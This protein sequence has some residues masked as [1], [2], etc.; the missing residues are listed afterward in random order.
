MSLLHAEQR[1][2]RR[3][4]KQPRQS[5]LA[6]PLAT[7]HPDQ[8]LTFLEWCRL[9]RFSERTGRRVINSGT[10]PVVTQLSAKRI[11][12]SIANNA[13]WQASKARG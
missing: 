5:A 10:G 13:K 2:L 9:N 12:I 7:S 3:K 11:G 6:A 1:R 8:I 4:R